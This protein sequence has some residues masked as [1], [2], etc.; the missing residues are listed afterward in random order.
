MTEEQFS[1]KKGRLRRTLL[2]ER[3]LV[4]MGPFYLV[5]APLLHMLFGW[6]LALVLFL[7]VWWSAPHF[8]AEET[9]GLGLWGSSLF[10]KCMAVVVGLLFTF[11]L[12]LSGKSGVFVSTLLFALM[13]LAAFYMEDFFNGRNAFA[14]EPEVLLMNLLAYALIYLLFLVLFGN[15]RWAVIFG[16]VLIYIFA[17]ACYFVMLF[18]GSPFVPLDI[19][20]SGTA[21]NVAENYVFTLSVP[22]TA[23]S[24]QTGLI[25]G[26]GFQLGRANLRRVRWCI[27]MRALAAFLLVGT[28]GIFFSQSYLTEKGYVISYWNQAESYE[29]YGDWLSFCINLR[30]VYPE[31]PENYNAETVSA[32]VDDV[33]D[34]H[35]ISPDGENAYNMISGANDYTKTDQTPNIIMVM[36]ESFTDLQAKGEGFSTNK[37]VLP[38]FNSLKENTIRGNLQVSVTGGGTACT[39]YEVL[40]GNAQRFL[41]SGA[42]AYSANLRDNTPSLAWTL[43]EQGYSTAAF[44]PLYG[45]GWNREEAYNYLGFESKTFLENVLPWDIISMDADERLKAVEAFDEEDGDVYNCDYMSDHYNYKVVEDLYE[46]RDK[47][48]PFFMFNVTIQNHGGYTKAADNFKETIHITDMKG[49]YPQAERYLSLVNASDKAF[50]ELVNYFKKVKEPTIIVMFGDHIPGVEEEFYEELYGKPLDELTTEEL[51]SYYQ[52]PFV[53]WANY[54]IP[55]KEMGTV[56][57]NYLSTLVLETAGLELPQ[58]NRYL[59]SLYSDVPV[60]SSVGFRDAE[61]RSAIRLEGQPYESDIEGYQCVAYNNLLDYKNRD[62]SL[63]TL[64]GKPLT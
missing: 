61:G 43:R 20:S 18:R 31:R 5:R 9:A 19:L 60:V 34:E 64:D 11:R 38:F 54:D 36:N 37:D 32:V 50:E 56:S 48:K 22:W 58:Y 59:A 27:T 16:T 4:Q 7:M 45:N 63:F 13:P 52:T 12:K 35:G 49:D 47:D 3:F 51:Q 1:K 41:P 28:V 17:A 44:H 62:W 10:L 25:L 53:I 26:V 14:H 24:V 40:T 15:Y 21:V 30:N 8:N 23:A 33:L 2:G 29:K 6:L 42:V 46:E 39:E 55:E 57:A